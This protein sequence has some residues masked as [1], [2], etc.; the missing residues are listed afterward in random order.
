[1]NSKYRR[2]EY[3]TNGTFT[4]EKHRWQWLERVVNL[5]RPA[6]E[7]YDDEYD[8]SYED[9]VYPVYYEDGDDDKE[10]EAKHLNFIWYTLRQN[11]EMIQVSQAPTRTTRTKKRKAT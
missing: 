7:E 2:L 5:P 6:P 1:M 11:P 9:D 3:L 4:S 10:R 8:D